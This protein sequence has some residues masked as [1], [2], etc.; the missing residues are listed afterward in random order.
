MK[1]PFFLSTALRNELKLNA[2][3]ENLSTLEILL[4]IFFLSLLHLTAS[5]RCSRTR[6]KSTFYEFC[7]CVSLCLLSVPIQSFCQSVTQENT[8]D[9]L[10]K[11][12]WECHPFAPSSVFSS[13]VLVPPQVTPHVCSSPTT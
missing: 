5:S 3:L 9:L 12:L 1:L 7:K 4:I 6:C 2:E 8:T 11:P 13:L 10:C